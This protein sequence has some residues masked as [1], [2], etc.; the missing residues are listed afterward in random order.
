MK[1]MKQQMTTDA[2]FA[3]YKKND[4]VFFNDMCTQF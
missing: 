3:K 1:F 4:M 2:V